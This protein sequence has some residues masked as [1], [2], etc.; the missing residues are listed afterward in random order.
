M[1]PPRSSRSRS[2]RALVALAAV[3]VVMLISVLGNETASPG[4]WQQQFK[5]GLGLDLS[6]GTN[7]VLQ[8]E[9]RNDSPPAG[10]EM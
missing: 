9:T 8:A 4:K 3:I 7:V 10:G 2:V 5:V 6:S 1:T